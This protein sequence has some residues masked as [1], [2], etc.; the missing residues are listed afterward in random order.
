MR[1][2]GLDLNQLVALDVLLA[3]RSVTKA[4]ARVF[5]SQS[6]MSWC[7]ARLREHFGDPLLVSV[8]RGLVLTPFAEG[9]AGQVRELLLHTRQV[10]SQRPDRPIAEVERTF[11][12]M[13]SDYVTTTVLGDVYRRAET[14]A[15]R[16]KLEL[17]SVAEFT[18]SVIETGEIDLLI[19]AEQSLSLHRPW[20]L[21]LR[22]EYVGLVWRDHPEVADRLTEK[23]YGELSHVAVQWG[24]GRVLPLDELAIREQQIGRRNQIIVPEFGYLP[25]FIVGTR[26]VATVQRRLA[27]IFE[28]QWPLRTVELPV[29]VPPISIGMQWHSLIEH[30]P[31]L[32]WMRALLKEVA[33]QPVTR[34]E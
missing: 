26:R 23:Q 19:A 20:E 2:D 21:L 29:V 22:D 27:R 12:I 15:P 18:P 25:G 30:D 11:R 10:T 14:E 6:A 8:G 3:E 7:L 24:H 16:V 9:L 32:K 33:A 17:R 1:F 4:A 13:T 34:M 31:A 28:Q 5:L